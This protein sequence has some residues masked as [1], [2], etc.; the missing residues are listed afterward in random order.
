MTSL[1]VEGV[2]S[3][4][5]TVT[6]PP[7]KS[8]THRALLL[9]ALGEGRCRVSSLG[10]GA[11]N[12]ATASALRALG[13]AVEIDA[14]ARTAEV[15]G[16]QG[17]SGLRAPAGP[18]DCANSGTTLRL[19]AGVLAA[20]PDGAVTLTG[21][22][23]LSARPMGRLRPLEAMGARLTGTLRGD[24]LC[25]PLTVHGAA[26]VGTS[27]QL[28]IASAQVKS[29]LLL[30]G[31]WASGTTSVKEPERS[32]D[33][34]E[35]ML[36]ALGVPV[37]EG[38]DG[39]LS[40]RA[41]GAPW[42]ADALVV[43]PDFSSAAFILAAA[44][45][46]R[47]PGVEVI[48]AL[49]P[50]RTGFLDVLSAMGVRLSIRP[51]GE[52]GGE[53]MGAVSVEAERLAGAEVSGA[54]TLRAIDEIPLV[55]AMA[56][57]AEGESVIRDAA[58]LRVKESDRLAR[59]A[60]LLRAFGAEVEERPDGLRVRS[61]ARRGATVTSHGDHRLAMTAAVLGLALPGETV[62]HGAEAIDVSFPEFDRS[63]AALGAKIRA[64]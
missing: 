5:G 11:D 8:I 4:A 50:T 38:D 37:L 26:L 63:L 44:A 64:R 6:A 29:A 59:S 20:R 36:R 60:E 39:T 9:A 49:N 35:R 27:H 48:T 46:T 10:L 13:V 54:L 21:D 3:L 12:L 41:L 47:S 31:L 62:V 53:P 55:A 23:S 16:V 17:P 32:R 19:L 1:R 61:P 40:V 57:M 51:L 14:E 15:L 7:D 58:E 34:T 25:P 18:I 22:E 30:A 2:A 24:K 52:A 42:R 56:A 28:P 45:L 43:A 33:H